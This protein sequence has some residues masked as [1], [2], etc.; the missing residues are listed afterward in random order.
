MVYRATS[1]VAAETELKFFFP[2]RLDNNVGYTTNAGYI[3]ASYGIEIMTNPNLQ[4]ID[5]SETR[6]GTDCS[7]SNTIGGGAEATDVCSVINMTNLG[8]RIAI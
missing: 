3:E 7:A 1:G 6:N 2:G 5:S 4:V 8:T